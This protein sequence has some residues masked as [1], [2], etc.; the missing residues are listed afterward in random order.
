MV[1]VFVER[2]QPEKLLGIRRVPFCVHFS[3][4][5]RNVRERARPGGLERDWLKELWSG[6]NSEIHKPASTILA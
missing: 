6:G 2:L 4:T 5:E 3:N 1:I